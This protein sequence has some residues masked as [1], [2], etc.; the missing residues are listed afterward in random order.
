[1]AQRAA[2]VATMVGAASATAVRQ[3]AARGLRRPEAFLPGRVGRS[4][5][6]GRQTPTIRLGRPGQTLG[7]SP[8]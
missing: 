4:A 8:P 5:R 2:Y 3:K 6:C 7:H 1:M